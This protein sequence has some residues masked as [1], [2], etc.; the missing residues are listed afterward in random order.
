[1]GVQLFELRSSVTELRS[2]Q[3]SAGCIRFDVPPK[4]G[5]FAVPVVSGDLIAVI[6]DGVERG[7][8]CS[9]LEHVIRGY[10]RPTPLLAFEAKPL[11]GGSGRSS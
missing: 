10:R 9:W 11:P 3:R 7:E 1:M 6:V 2:F 5:P 4:H 8:G